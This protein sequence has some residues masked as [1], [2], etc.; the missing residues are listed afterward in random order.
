[1]R[2]GL[3][4]GWGPGLE[5]GRLRARGWVLY[6]ELPEGL[7]IARSNALRSVYNDADAVCGEIAQ[8][9][10]RKDALGA[11]QGAL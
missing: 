1:M 7:Q 9:R 8:G 2:W 6:K 10:G 3:E 4:R 11:L 5:P